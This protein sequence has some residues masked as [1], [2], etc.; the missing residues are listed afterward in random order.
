[1]KHEDQNFIVCKMSFQSSIEVLQHVTKEHS[2][3]IIEN[4]SVKEKEQMEYSKEGKG[5]DS[6][7]ESDELKCAKCDKIVLQEDNITI[8]EEEHSRCQ[9]CQMMTLYG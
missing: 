8:D 1:M 2:H 9:F 4:I 5:S 3:N 6:D 7:V